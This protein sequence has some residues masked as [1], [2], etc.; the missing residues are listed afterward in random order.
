M[1]GCDDSGLGGLDY[2]ALRGATEAGLRAPFHAGIIAQAFAVEAAQVA[3]IRAEAANARGR[4]R[5]AE[6]E[7][8]A[9]TAEFGTVEPQADVSGFRVP[10]AQVQEVHHHFRAGG[11]ALQTKPDALA[12][13]R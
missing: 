7:A 6:K 13:L 11:V 3:D 1:P 2:A 10:A 12:P 9:Q 8:G 5:A 4:L